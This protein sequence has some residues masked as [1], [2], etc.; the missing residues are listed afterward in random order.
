MS[1]RTQLQFVWFASYFLKRLFDDMFVNVRIQ[2]ESIRRVSYHAK[3]KA[4]SKW[5]NE[6]NRFEQPRLEKGLCM[7]Q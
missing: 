6:L 1:E 3:K 4:S 2:E 7:F 5:V